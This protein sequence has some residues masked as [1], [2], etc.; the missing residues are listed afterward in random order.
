[1]NFKDLQATWFNCEKAQFAWWKLLVLIPLRNLTSAKW[2]LKCRCFSYCH[3]HIKGTNDAH[4][5]ILYVIFRSATVALNISLFKIKDYFDVILCTGA[6]TF[7]LCP[8]CSIL[9]SFPLPLSQPCPLLAQGLN[10]PTARALCLG[11]AYKGYPICLMSYSSKCTKNWAFRAVWNFFA[12]RDRMHIQGL[13]NLAMF[14]M[15]I[16]NSSE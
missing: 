7:S 9:A 3:F 10:V 16:P 4:F 11:W 5:H 8:V 1:M 13:Q 14:N 15:S 6:A 12:H 2:N